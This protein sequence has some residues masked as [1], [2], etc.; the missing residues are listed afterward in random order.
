MDFCFKTEMITVRLITVVY[1]YAFV[2]NMDNLRLAELRR[3]PRS[4]S[5][6]NLNVKTRWELRIKLFKFSLKIST[7]IHDKFV[8]TT[9]FWVCPL[10]LDGMLD[11]KVT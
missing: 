4:D 3:T 2:E 7:R 10:S 11:Y 8:L 5:K 6:G 9:K 1:T